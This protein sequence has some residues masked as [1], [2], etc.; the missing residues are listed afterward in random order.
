MPASLRGAR[1]PTIADAVR[2]NSEGSLT[3][4]E[5]LEEALEALAATAGLGAVVHLDEAAARSQADMLDAM[6]A[7]GRSLGPL[8]GVPITV[9]DVIHVSGMPTRAGSA[10]YEH[11]Q[12][13]EGTAVARLRAAGALVFAKV[14]THEFAMG[15]TTPQ[16]RNP[17]DPTVISGGSSGGSAIAVATGVGLASL[18]TDTRASL[19][20]PSALCGV[21]GFKPTLG[22]VPIDGI[23]PL[24]WTM[25][26]IGPIAAS[27]DDAVTVMEVLQHASLGDR[28][29]QSEGRPPVV[30]V[31]PGTIES[32][33]SSV[34]GAV[35]G[36][37]YRMASAGWAVCEAAS[38][39]LD[40]LDDANAIGLLISRSEAGAFHR[41]RRTDFARCIPEVRD[42]LLA[43][44]GVSAVDYLD[45]QRQRQLLAMRTVD[46]MASFD[47]LAMPTTPVVAPPIEDYEA[48]LLVL[49]RYAIIW[50]LVGCPAITLPCGTSPDG[51]PVGIQLVAKPGDDALL[52]RTARW[53]EQILSRT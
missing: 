35:E 52:V 49:S 42:Q 23:V 10:T 7:T 27:V 26:H 50:S 13:P 12:P 19:R 51:L 17:H 11:L 38:P 14:A 33:T 29:A 46:A 37:L 21:V 36:A 15:V 39:T 41:A 1:T 31:V 16:C 5:L 47:V 30:G 22:T 28:T 2:R 53:L 32:A 3:C 9:K 18:G 45:A 20:V 4:R 43:A 6:A 8:H 44:L 24:S 48:Y 25:D 34:A 40:D